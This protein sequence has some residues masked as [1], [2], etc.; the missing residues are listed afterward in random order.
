MI[1][2]LSA[3]HSARGCCSQRASCLPLMLSHIPSSTRLRS[4]CG[5]FAACRL[6]CSRAFSS[7]S[8]AASAVCSLAAAARAVTHQQCT[9]RRLPHFPALIYLVFMLSCPFFTGSRWL[10]P[11]PLFACAKQ[12]RRAKSCRL[13][14]TLTLCGCGNARQTILSLIASGAV[15]CCRPLC[16]P[17]FPTLSSSFQPQLIPRGGAG[18]CLPTRS[19]PSARR[20]S[21]AVSG[22]CPSFTRCASRCSRTPRLVSLWNAPT[23]C[24][25]V[26]ALSLR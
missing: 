25:T 23:R 10:L 26:I 24:L 5:A 7:F 9:R 17:H 4:M 11:P 19:T 8:S 12:S 15:C 21:C 20:P 22:R 16:A 2:A 13:R 3:G 1:C 6:P 18:S 14:A